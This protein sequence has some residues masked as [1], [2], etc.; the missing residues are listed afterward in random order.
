MG[1]KNGQQDY[2]PVDR[3]VIDSIY[4]SNAILVTSSMLTA[5]F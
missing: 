5:E 2:F 4:F 3:F 1:K